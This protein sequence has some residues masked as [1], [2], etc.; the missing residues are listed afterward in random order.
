MIEMHSKV[1]LFVPGTVRVSQIADTHKYVEKV[2]TSF[3]RWFGGATV[4][5]SDG[6]YLSTAGE[7]VS[8]RTSIVWSYCTTESLEE[9]A[10]SVIE[11][12]EEVCH[13]LQ[14]ECVAVVINGTMCL[15]ESE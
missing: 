14:Q 1:E 8:E 6:Y 4:T 9:Y 3:C 15:V 11:L 5:S 10:P 12:A 7:L 2:A 13:E